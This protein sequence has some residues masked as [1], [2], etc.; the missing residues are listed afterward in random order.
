MVVR[1]VCQ[2]RRMDP[3]QVSES[4]NLVEELGFDSL[5]AAE[6]LVALHN[7]TGHQLNVD[8]LKGMQTVK[9]IAY[10]LVHE[11]NEPEMSKQI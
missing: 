9:D 5:D 6:L 1:L 8:S 2:G 11:H 10:S 7:E 3:S 4:T